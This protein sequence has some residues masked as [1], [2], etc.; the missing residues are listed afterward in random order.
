[1]RILS[2]VLL[3]AILA[4]AL[5]A[6]SAYATDPPPRVGAE[7]MRP[8]PVPEPAAKPT[9]APA[10]KPLRRRAVA[11]QLDDG[12][13]PPTYAPRLDPQP[14]R[15]PRDRSLQE[16]APPGPVIL[17]G[18]NGAAH[19]MDQGGSRYNPV[20]TSLIS[21]SGRVCSNNGISVSCY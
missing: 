18:C 20:G 2:P 11:A 5:P 4:L 3:M 17:N 7:R 19:C 8:D 16:P 9:P 10:K 21:P 12:M 15:P 1:M 6:T 14:A 13:N